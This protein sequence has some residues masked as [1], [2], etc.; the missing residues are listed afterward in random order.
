[1]SSNPGDAKYQ[2]PLLAPILV[3]LRQDTPVHKLH[4]LMQS[5][6]DQGCLPE[7][8]LTPEIQLFRTNFLLMNAL[9]QLQLRL[10]DCDI[11]LNV[12]PLAIRLETRQRVLEL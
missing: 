1:M 3:L 4:E 11:W 12:V 2:N 7:W 5:L 10:W 8:G 6:A 9:Y